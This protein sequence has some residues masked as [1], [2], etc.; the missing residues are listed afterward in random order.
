MNRGHDILNEIEIALD[1][2]CRCVLTL[3]FNGTRVHVCGVSLGDCVGKAR[4]MGLLGV[5]HEG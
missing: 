1:V 3:L 5:E 2:G 4:D